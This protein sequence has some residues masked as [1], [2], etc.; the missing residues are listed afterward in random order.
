[1]I[2]TKG[3]WRKGVAPYESEN[4]IFGTDRDDGSKQLVAEVFGHSNEQIAANVSAI[5][6]WCN[7]RQEV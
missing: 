5:L 1:M 4:Q 7:W 2:S 3:P 6:A